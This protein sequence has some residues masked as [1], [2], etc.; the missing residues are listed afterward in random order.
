MVA[1]ADEDAS[2]RHRGGSVGH[3]STELSAPALVMDLP[4]HVWIGIPTS[5]P[6]SVFDRFQRAM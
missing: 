4:L 5:Q 2:Y 6:A 3:R 1:I